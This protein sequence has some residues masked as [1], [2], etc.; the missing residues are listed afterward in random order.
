MIFMHDAMR[1]HFLIGDGA[2][3]TADAA[4]FHGHFSLTTKPIHAERRTARLHAMQEFFLAFTLMEAM[5]S[6]Y[7]QRF[8]KSFSPHFSAGPLFNYGDNAILRGQALYRARCRTPCQS[9]LSLVMA[10]HRRPDRAFTAEYTSH[11][12]TRRNTRA[13][14]AAEEAYA[15]GLS[16]PIYQR[17]RDATSAMMMLPEA[18]RTRRTATRNRD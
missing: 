15:A 16:V 10:P 6:F 12:I 13:Q 3:I 2:L 8:L 14:A 5:L 4:R 9:P 17:R 1:S 11:F 18:G 7:F